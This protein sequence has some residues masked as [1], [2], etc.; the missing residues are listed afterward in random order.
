MSLVCKRGDVVLV[1]RKDRW[2]PDMKWI[3]ATN[4][5]TNSRGAI[6]RGLLLFLPTLSRPS[7]DTLPV[8]F[9]SLP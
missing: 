7:G 6:H 5:R 3:R 9:L 8:Q 4:Q 2:A 1:K